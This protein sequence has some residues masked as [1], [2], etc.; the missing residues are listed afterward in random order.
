[1]AKQFDGISDGY[2]GGSST[3]LGR[4]GPRER[5]FVKPG[6]RMPNGKIWTGDGRLN[7]LISTKGHLERQI[8]DLQVKLQKVYADIFKLERDMVKAGVLTPELATTIDVPEPEEPALEEAAPKKS[9]RKKKA[10]EPAE[11]D[12]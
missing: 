7:S 5:K 1:M 3:F 12:S 10:D 8:G 4:Q 11:S 9:T 2:M 6:D